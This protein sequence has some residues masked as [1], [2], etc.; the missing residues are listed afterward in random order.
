MRYL[1]IM[2]PFLLGCTTIRVGRPEFYTCR[3]VVVYSKQD[4]WSRKYETIQV[5]K[6]ITQEQA[7]KFF[8]E[9]R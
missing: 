9:M 5:C 8:Q 4:I 6:P 3:Q 2:L 7:E 1:A